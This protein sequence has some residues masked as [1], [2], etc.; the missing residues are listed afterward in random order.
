MTAVTTGYSQ[1]HV[2]EEIFFSE[3]QPSTYQ[4]AVQLRKTSVT[5]S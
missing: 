4:M 2:V 5:K 3:I 1:T